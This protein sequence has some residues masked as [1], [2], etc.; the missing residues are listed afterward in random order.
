MNIR[1]ADVSEIARIGEIDRT[2]SVEVEFL[3]RLAQDGRSIEMVEQRLE[4]PKI[5]TDWDDE[6][7][8]RRAAWWTREVEEGG[9]M[10]VAELDA[11][12]IGIAILGP[13]KPG[14]CAEIVS[15]FVDTQHRGNG[16]GK[17]LIQRLEDE[18]RA[19]G[20]ESI[21]VGSN[22]NANALGF[23]QSVGYRIVCLMDSSTMWIP[24]LETRIVLAKGL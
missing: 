1:R 21:Y 13:P 20:I 9:V 7:V 11:K 18:G 19:R 24:G 23:Y 12:L 5:T 4:P 17:Q 2:E 8:R 6:G 16:L 15:M 14:K 3:C 22:E 10:F